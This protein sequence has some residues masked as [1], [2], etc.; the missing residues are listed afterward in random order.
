MQKEKEVAEDE[1]VRYHHRLNK[2]EFEQ[3][4][5]DTAGQRSLDCYSPCT[6][7]QQF[8]QDLATEQQKTYC[9][10]RGTLLNAL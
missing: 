1:M 5:G 6:A 7:V 2:H 10:A 4:P 9:T 8:G 3:S